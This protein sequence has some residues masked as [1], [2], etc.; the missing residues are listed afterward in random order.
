VRTA[1]VG[2]YAEE[3][4]IVDEEDDLLAGLGP[5]FKAWV[6]H[7]DEVSKLPD[8]FVRLAHSR[9]C[10]IEAMARPDLG[11]YGVQFHPEVEHTPVGPKIFE[12]FLRIC[13]LR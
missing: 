3:E 2:E 9:T 11:L 12:N 6:S 13:K 5:R 10:E 7:K 8:G 1:E 4:I